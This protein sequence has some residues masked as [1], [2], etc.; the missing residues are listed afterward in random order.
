M[1]P[2]ILPP[3]SGHSPVNGVIAH[4]GLIRE[5]DRSVIHCGRRFEG[6]CPISPVCLQY[7]QQQA[8][9]QRSGRSLSGPESLEIIELLPAN[10]ENTAMTPERFARIRKV[11][12]LR[13]P[14]LT[15]VME[16]V[17]KPHNLAAIARSCDAVGAMRVH[18][19]FH[20]PADADLQL[21][22]K[23]ASG[24]SKW[25]DVLVHAA[26]GDCLDELGRGG[27]QRLSLTIDPTAADYR[28]FD[29]TQPTALVVGA[30]LD[31]LSEEAVRACDR[32][33]YIPMQ[34]M[35]DSLNVSVAAALVLFEARRQ[36]EAKGLYD[37]PRIDP[38]PFAKKLF[39]WTQPV[40][41]E[42]CQRHGLDY[43]E[44]TDDG[45]VNTR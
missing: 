20:E 19:V 5:D 38:E 31:G 45:D 44:L 33:V 37:A 15:V 23:S 42:Y 25:V 8:Q 21:S 9:C 32:S 27:Y 4:K 16:N 43:P 10:P 18:S 2:C 40:V 34:G 35:V 11:L 41:A 22:Q 7:R 14:D 26:L 17:H 13:Q 1:R 6:A 12:S 24:A 3:T 28:A 30:E 29:Y 39:E 36:R